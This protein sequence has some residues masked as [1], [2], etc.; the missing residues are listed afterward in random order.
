M[1][2]PQEID[3]KFAQSVLA[4]EEAIFEIEDIIENHEFTDDQRY[5]LITSKRMSE[6]ARDLIIGVIA[7]INGKKLPKR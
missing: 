3:D 4:L 1:T 7:S 6:S 2:K 5:E